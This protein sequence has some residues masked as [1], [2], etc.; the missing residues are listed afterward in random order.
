[1]DRRYL[2]PYLLREKK[3]SRDEKLLY[4][5]K[6]IN[7]LNLNKIAEDPEFVFKA[8]TSS[9]TQSTEESKKENCT[10]NDIDEYITR[11]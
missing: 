11:L 1:M 5:F 3:L 4:T 2:K 9:E 10:K 8:A 7:E 6:K